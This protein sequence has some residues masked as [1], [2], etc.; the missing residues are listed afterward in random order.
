[1]TDTSGGEPAIACPRAS[2]TCSMRGTSPGRTPPT[3]TQRWP[4]A[5]GPLRNRRSRPRRRIVVSGTE[6]QPARR[7]AATAQLLPAGPA[8]RGR[9]ADHLPRLR[10]RFPVPV[11][12]PVRGPRR[13]T[14]RHRRRLHLNLPASGQTTPPGRWTFFTHRASCGRQAILGV[15]HHRRSGDSRLD[16]RCSSISPRVRLPPGETMTG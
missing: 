5:G 10:A 13:P 3:S 4:P 15:I 16:A 2:S 7:T 9:P 14:P 8:H 11:P 6:T 1:M 12:Q